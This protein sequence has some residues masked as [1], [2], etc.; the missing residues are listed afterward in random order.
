M[1][2]YPH[3]YPANMPILHRNIM[4]GLPSDFARDVF[5]WGI[6]RPGEDPYCYRSEATA[7]E[8]HRLLVSIQALLD[9]QHRVAGQMGGPMMSKEQRADLEHYMMVRWSNW[10]YGGNASLPLS[11]MEAA[12]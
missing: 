9:V 1:K 11:V 12:E 3:P 5:L 2:S 8:A 6:E 4:D 10:R 7:N